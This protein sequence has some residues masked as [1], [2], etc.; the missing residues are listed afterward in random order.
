MTGAP[1]TSALRAA[2]AASLCVLV[3][4]LGICQR[5]DTAL[6]LPL[7]PLLGA[8]LTTSL[9]VA[10][11]LRLLRMEQDERRALSA[12]ASNANAANLFQR[13]EETEALSIARTRA[14]FERIVVPI[15]A[16]ALACL[17][18]LCAWMI[19]R[20]VT[21]LDNDAMPTLQVAA[22]L[23]GESFL[24]FL[25]GRY[26]VGRARNEESRLTKGP[27]VWLCITSA[28]CLAAAVA[29][30]V[31]DY[32]FPRVELFTTLALVLVLAVLAVELLLNVIGELYRPGKNMGMTTSYE[33][34][35]AALAADPAPWV[36]NVAKAVD[37]QFGFNVSDSWFFRFL[38]GA[39]LPLLL[40]QAAALYALSSMVFIGPNES[41]ILERYGA[42]LEKEWQLES[43]FHWKRPW[44]FESVRRYST[45]LIHR[46]HAGRVSSNEHA[47]EEHDREPILWTS[48]H[49]HEEELFL[50]A[51][52]AAGDPRGAM[53]VGFVNIDIP[54][55]YRI[56]DIREYAYT[57]SDPVQLVK[58]LVDQAI[59]RETTSHD[60]LELITTDRQ[61]TSDR[62]RS[63]LQH[64]ADNLNLGIE[65]LS[66]GVQGLHPP[67]AVAGAFEAS[68]AAA[69]EKKA[70]IA[71]A[72]AYAQR[73]QPL[74]TATA[75]A[76]RREAQAYTDRRKAVSEAE[77][78]QFNKLLTL[79]RSS[80]TVF[81]NRRY[82]RVMNRALKHTRK[83]IVS[84]TSADEVIELNFE[85]KLPSTLFDL[86]PMQDENTL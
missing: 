73:Q 39:L 63:Q 54:V 13:A 9:L 55:E 82:L 14:Q 67:Q 17:M 41:G 80:P 86:G 15:T 1:G 34:R 36:N 38:Q 76:M 27:G 3:L 20:T 48:S 83:Y 49:H 65:V 35:L 24:L 21:S 10:T 40:F 78:E 79:H 61:A 68:L 4:N 50:T 30:V 2:I 46:V 64:L 8:C 12:E 57:S 52:R 5:Y 32:V 72:R 31:A 26:L 42:P 53:P 60:L 56:R 45:K 75:E 16:P 69:E 23:V 71:S 29:L 6:L 44:P 47:H 62:L 19:A 59:T 22:L 18:G 84:A 58:Q 51:S 11:R 37:Y 74:A 81:R 66:V 70:F 77:E 85:E 43:G 7:L 28:S 25:L 33:S